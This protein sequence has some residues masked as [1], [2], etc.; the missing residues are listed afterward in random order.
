MTSNRLKLFLLT[1]VSFVLLLTV[2]A[3]GD[4]H[5]TILKVEGHYNYQHG[6]NYDIE[7]GHIDVRET[8]T[9]D[10]FDDSTAL[11]SAQQVYVLALN[12]GNHITWTFNYIS[13]SYWHVDGKDFYFV[14]ISESFRM[15]PIESSTEDSNEELA[16][17]LA[18]KIIKSVSSG[19][20]R[21]I[22]FHMDTLTPQELVWSYTYPDGHTDTWEFY[23]Q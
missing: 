12:D 9:M 18:E 3:C 1:T 20:D 15:E 7:E 11:D 22:K 5:K 2:V 8:G 4:S 13:P 17:V 21:E 6:W 19:I 10:F 23:R 16:T 14:G